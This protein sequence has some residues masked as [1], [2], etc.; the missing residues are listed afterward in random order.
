M[1][2]KSSVKIEDKSL[3]EF[4]G[5][6]HNEQDAYDNV[7]YSLGDFSL[8]DLEKSIIN[9]FYKKKVIKN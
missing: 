1:L 9:P 2:I 8:N 6:I 7:L 3:N 4:L 5:K